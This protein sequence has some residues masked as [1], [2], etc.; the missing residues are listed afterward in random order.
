[1]LAFYCLGWHLSLLRLTPITYILHRLWPRLIRCREQGTLE[2]KVEIDA[3]K[4][5]LETSVAAL[6]LETDTAPLEL[7]MN[8]TP[9]ELEIEMDVSQEI[10]K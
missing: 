2:S 1:L 4:L 7:E 9:L 3:A 5:E 10:S 8:A 6:E